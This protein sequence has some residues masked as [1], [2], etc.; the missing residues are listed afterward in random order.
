MTE[1]P[2][3]EL[4]FGTGEVAVVD[5][6][7]RFLARIREIVRDDASGYADAADLVRAA[8]RAE[9]DR[10]EKGLFARGRRKW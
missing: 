5:L 4:N 3:I 2:H 7:S 10:A 9:V 8:L 1:G 6:T